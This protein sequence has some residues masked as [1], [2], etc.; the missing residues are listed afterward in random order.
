MISSKQATPN[1]L[2]AL[3]KKT[4]KN[5]QITMVCLSVLFSSYIHAQDNNSESEPSA[6]SAIS[7]ATN[8][9]VIAE[10]VLAND[11]TDTDETTNANVSVRNNSIAVKSTAVKDDNAT[12]T[13]ATQTNEPALEIAPNLDLKEVVETPEITAPVTSTATETTPKNTEIKPAP[14]ESTGKKMVLLGAEVPPATSTRL[15]WKPVSDISDLTVPTPVL[16]ING[17]NDGPTLCL[18]AAVHGD[19]LNGIEIIRRVM[20][21]IDPKL[22]SG[23]LIGVPVVN[24]LGFQRNSRYLPDRRDLNRAFPGEPNGSLAARIAHSLFNEVITKCDRLIDL[25]TGSMLR[26]NLP[27]IRAEMTNPAVAEFVQNFDDMLVIHSESEGG[28]LRTAANNAG[29][30]A[31]TMEVGES[32]RIQV[33]QIKAGTYSINSFLARTGMYSRMFTWGKA[34]PAYYKSQWVRV[35]K[36]GILFSDAKLGDFVKKGD[37][38]GKVTNPINNK[39]HS[40]RSTVNG[41]I[42]GMAIDQVVMPGFAAYH[43]GIRATENELSEESNDKTEI[44]DPPEAENPE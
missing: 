24:L 29:I 6:P 1:T 40:V 3:R 4:V 21:N 16:V 36:G 13:D 30:A 8:E 44:V 27:Q 34:Q 12:A 23:K 10:A 25:H 32:M 28:M 9:K 41:R 18:T 26:T 2:N 33:D 39:T 31:I 42:I 38:L 43:I 7:V 14:A 5:C 11:H 20:Y 22:L 35:S 19:E 17:A 37:P 15:Q